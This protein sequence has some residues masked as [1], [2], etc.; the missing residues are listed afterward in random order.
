M[1][2]G[3]YSFSTCWNVKK[4]ASGLDMI[5]E[6]GALGFKQVELNYNVTAQHLQEIEPLILRG[7]VKVSSVH[8]VFPFIEDPA[9]DTDSVMLGFEN[10]AM[11]RQAVELLKRS[12][13]Y[14]AKYGAGAVV[15]HPGEVPFESNIDAELKRIYREQGKAS[16]AYRALWEQM[17]ARRNRLAPVFQ[18]RIRNS[19]EEV[20]EYIVR[21][22][23]SV[24]IGIETRARCYQMPTL[25]EAGELI[26]GLRGAPLGLWYDIGHAMM[27][28]RMG[29][30]DNLRQVQ[31][32]RPFIIGVHIHETIGLSDHFC[33][34]VHSGTRAEFDPFLDIIDAAPIK[35]YELKASCLPADIHESHRRIT[36]YIKD[37]KGEQQ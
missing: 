17:L 30:Y 15:L 26:S 12:V 5:R 4:H 25:Q 7:E 28:D 8:H 35:V 24:Q 14:A 18:A 19:L 13:D 34:Y 21:N 20:C 27:M 36:Q 16:E 23:Y 22:A 37:R 9:F 2:K 10:E 29:L 6:I 32:V 11:R 31:Q 33:P 1:D 3:N